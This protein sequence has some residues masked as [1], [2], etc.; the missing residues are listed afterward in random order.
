MRLE[1]D[2]K[3][4]DITDELIA[5]SRA[6]INT[7]NVTER[8]IDITNRFSLPDTN[9]NRDIFESGQLL[10]SDSNGF[11]KTY[12]AKIIDQD[13]LFNGIAFIKE[14][15]DRIFK[16]QLSE[17]SKSL[18][19]AM[20]DDIN[21]LDFEQYD[22]TFN[23][24]SYDILKVRG[25]DNIWAWPV[26]S[27]H[28]DNIISKSRY[29]AGNDGLKYSRPVLNYKKLIDSI[30]AAQKWSLTFSNEIFD[31]LGLSVNHKNFFV[32]S[33]QKTLTQIIAGNGSLTGLDVND[34]EFGVTTSNTDI[35]I[36]N[37][38]TAFRLRGNITATSL[39]TIKITSTYGAETLTE[40][41]KVE[42]GTNAVDF[43]TKAFEGNTGT[44]SVAISVEGT[45]QITFDDTL[46][47]TIISEKDLAPLSGN[48]LLGYRVK[49]HDNLPDLTQKEVFRNLLLM[50]N[51]VIIPDS[52]S[53][54]ITLKSLNKLN[55][56]NAYDWS[57]KFE[58]GSQFVINRPGDLSQ[59]N[60]LTYDND[61]S[62]FPSLGK[63]S[64]PVDNESLDKVGTFIELDY[65]ASNQVI[66]NTFNT[67]EFSIYNDDERND[68]INIRIVYLYD[69]DDITPVFSIGRF[70]P[71]D[72]RS[73]KELYY[74]NWL[75]SHR[76]YRMVEGLFDLKKLDVLSFDFLKL[77]YI[78]ELKSSFFVYE[79]ED[80]VPGRLTKLN[81]LKFL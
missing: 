24:A 65:G 9:N 46:L 70:T 64:F 23:Q 11:D 48:P 43:K 55:K 6:V 42:P 3:E 8:K 57:D 63:D 52:L 72:W 12:P 33:Y 14:Y 7:E 13:F 21:V 36:G 38:K 81:M 29:T 22:F 62:V 17:A 19:D 44:N 31:R 15:T 27:M 32:T 50:T 78:D 66:L 41:L 73:L 28:E 67:A 45:G 18:F 40:E 35:D 4:V 47:Y 53:K 30:F 60:E 58:K 74:T 1:I 59:V 80:F 71:L 10:A 75:E 79:I 26:I 37:T 5:I 54:V 77:V 25:V 49:V 20:K 56:N 39:Y 76:R 68:D 61:D 16:V 2:G 34:F 69:N 51:A